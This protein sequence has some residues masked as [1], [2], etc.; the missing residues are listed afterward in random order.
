MDQYQRDDWREL[1]PHPAA[2]VFPMMSDAETEAMRSDMRDRGYDRTYP[3]ILK[4]GL[5]LDGRNR[6]SVCRELGVAPWLIDFDG[7]DVAE[8]VVRANLNRRHLNP[9]Q[10]A[11]A[12]LEMAPFYSEKARERQRTAGGDK[13]SE[14]ARALLSNSREA[15][16]GGRD[17]DN[18]TGVQLGKLVGVGENAIY[19]AVLVSRNSPELAAEVKA[20]KKTLNAAVRIVKNKEGTKMTDTPKPKAKAK[21]PKR[22]M[23]LDL[24]ANERIIEGKME[25]FLDASYALF[26]IRERRLYLK[27]HGN[28]YSYLRD[29]WGVAFK[30]RPPTTAGVVDV[31]M[32]QSTGDT[33]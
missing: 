5:V 14:A 10:A 19:R 7:D 28:Y 9:G 18:R 25:V 16:S 13:V 33:K 4:D 24:E 29:R 26:D 17:R 1:Q 15:L 11:M 31:Q 6:L 20:G 2:Q 30:Q 23:D 32:S 12:A 27:T 8:F 21:A 22:Q 3:I